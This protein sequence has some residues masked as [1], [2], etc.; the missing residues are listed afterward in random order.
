MKKIEAIIQPFHLDQV[1]QALNDLGIDSITITDVRGHGRP[2][3]QKQVYRGQEFVMDVL[4]QI[5]IEMVVPDEQSEDVVLA[6]SRAARS[7]DPGDGQIF[8][9]DIS[10]AVRIRTGFRGDLAL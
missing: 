10:D 6:V 4:P 3:G 9:S 1:K 2:N 7:G 5:K 8:I